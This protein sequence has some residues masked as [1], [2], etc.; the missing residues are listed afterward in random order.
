MTGLVV[1][2]IAGVR[3]VIESGSTTFH[4]WDEHTQVYF[5]GGWIQVWSPPLF[6]RPAQS[7][8][9]IYEGGDQPQM[10]KRAA[11]LTGAGVQMVALLA[12]SDDGRPAC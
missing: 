7:R 8:V 2:T 5:Q 9:E 12:L 10:L 4:A 3:S 11:A 6:A 1:L